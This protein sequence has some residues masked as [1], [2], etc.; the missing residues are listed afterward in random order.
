M[1]HKKVIWATIISFAVY[2]IVNEQLFGT[3][4]VN[5]NRIVNQQGVSH[6]LAY[7]IVGIP[8][9]AGLAF[10][11]GPNRVAHS[12]GIN[13]SFL[14]GMIVALLF[15]LPMFL[16][17]AVLF[18]FNKTMTLTGV[19]SGVVAAG[20]FEELYFRGF[21]FGQFYRFTKFGFVPSI[22]IGALLFASAHL[23]QSQDLT[24]LIGIF[25]T[26]FL[27]AILFAWVYV[28]WN[29][30]LWVAI[31][32]H[33]FMNLAW[34]MFSVSDNAFGGHYANI[35][36]LLTIIFVIVGTIIYKRRKGLK[37]EVTRKTLWMKHQV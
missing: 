29:Y 18:E 7:I 6:I 10:I 17:Y 24:T 31:F 26:T 23:Y 1:N 9:F 25:I 5:I 32:L 30:N 15:T 16:G 34:M 20:L 14:K 37:L 21:L 36:R 11:H 35:F 33:A 27:G 3:L 4:S 19:M 8:I 2:F 28:E 13:H 12:I 22:I